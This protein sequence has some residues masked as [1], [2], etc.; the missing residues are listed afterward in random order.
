MFFS[1]IPQ[2]NSQI[3]AR[4]VVLHNEAPRVLF[5]TA[6]LQ[7]LKRNILSKHSPN[8]EKCN[9]SDLLCYQQYLGV[10]T[11]ND[12]IISDMRTRVSLKIWHENSTV[13]FF[14]SH[15]YKEGKLL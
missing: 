13:F 6:N 5:A 2:L 10:L 7:C 3:Y 4:G 14:S 8:K 15:V 1:L 9:C 11:T 12:H